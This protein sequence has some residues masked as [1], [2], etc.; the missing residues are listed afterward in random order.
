MNGINRIL[1]RA[2]KSPDFAHVLLANRQGAIAAAGIALSPQEQAV[3]DSISD[4][5]LS[6]MIQSVQSAPRVPRAV[7]FPPDWKGMTFTGISPR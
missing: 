4:L 1:D 5:S 3:L 7:P 6:L 2:A